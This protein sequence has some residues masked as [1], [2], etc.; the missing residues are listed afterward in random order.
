V[1]DPVRVVQAEIQIVIVGEKAVH[2]W[3]MTRQSYARIPDGAVNRA[4]RGRNGR[5]GV[6]SVRK[7]KAGAE[8]KIV[9]FFGT[10]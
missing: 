5:S 10:E 3:L 1:S 4:N 9:E 2:D 7:K 6:E 8:Q